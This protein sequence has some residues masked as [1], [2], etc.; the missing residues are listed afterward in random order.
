[1]LTEAAP[2]RL[3]GTFGLA[4]VAAILFLLF[5][6]GSTP[7]SGNLVPPPWD[8]VVHFGVFATL[9]VGLRALFPR[10]PWPLLCLLAGGIAVG[11]EL[12]QFLVPT[13]HPDWDDGFADMVGVAGGLLAWLWLEKRLPFLRQ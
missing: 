12:H 6:F 11:D 3:A 10:L 9:A 4:I 1:M 2:R 8:K 5:G 7:A 13:R